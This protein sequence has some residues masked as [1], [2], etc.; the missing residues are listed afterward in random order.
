[1][2]GPAIAIRGLTKRFG[3]LVAIDGLDLEIPP[4]STVG[5]LGPAGAGK[6]TLVRLLCG[7]AR[8]TAGGISIAG[9]AMDGSG[10]IEARR[11]L[12]A[13]LRDAAFH[14]WMTVREVLAFAADLTGLAS[15]GIGE[16]VAAAA[17]RLGIEAW[18]DR[19]ASDLPV[20]VRA[21]LLVAQA[22][23]GE[24]EIL[25]LDEALADLDP[26]GEAAV[27]G[28]VA[29]RRGK[30]TTVLAS[31]RLGD[32][33]GLCDR[34]VVLAGGR[35]LADAPAATFLERHAPPV[36]VVET[37]GGAGLALDGLAAR[38]RAEPW[39]RDVEVGPGSLRVTVV[40]VDRAGRQLL[41]AVVGTGVAVAAFRRERPSLGE[42]VAGLGA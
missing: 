20:P 24:P 42:I 26:G 36:Y 38:L 17:R 8:P 13:A 6:S 11:H 15:G 34:I 41:T 33:E 27:R 21:R 30:R 39:V 12:G 19:R 37:V 4:G 2:D 29:S 40:D 16:E 7:L 22:L 5:L 23:V 32:L 1:M 18:L 28:L 25:L 10:G 9:H 31:D 35:V 14:G 3:K